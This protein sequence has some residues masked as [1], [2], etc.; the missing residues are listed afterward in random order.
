MAANEY[1]G[2]IIRDS[3]PDLKPN[4]PV[5]EDLFHK[6]ETGQLEKLYPKDC[7]EAYGKTFQ[8][9]H[10]DVLL[11]VNNENTDRNDTLFDIDLTI[12]PGCDK[13]GWACGKN[14]SST[15]DSSCASCSR[16]EIDDVKARGAWVVRGFLIDHCLSQRTE[17][18][19]KIQFSIPIASIVIV[20]NALKVVL[21][22]VITLK[23][24]EAPLMTIGD[25]IVSFMQRPD[26]TTEGMCL[27]SRADFENE[28]ELWQSGTGPSFFYSEPKRW[29]KAASKKRWAT[30]LLL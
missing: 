20:F 15:N 27:M 9:S 16:Q 5:A 23:V 1:K 12:R 11:M 2:F 18:K 8:A 3:I 28:K 17:E 7:V 19:C 13:S 4:D 21:F 14:V 6:A 26:H 30:V 22:S 29:S 25:A 24:Q 10:G